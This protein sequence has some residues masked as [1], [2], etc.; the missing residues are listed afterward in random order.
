[1]NSAEPN[2]RSPATA[3]WYGEVASPP[4]NLHWPA[5]DL[6]LLDAIDQSKPPGVWG[7]GLAARGGIQGREKMSPCL[8]G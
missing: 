5:A 1:V 8:K 7:M 4:L 2:V 3:R 6:D